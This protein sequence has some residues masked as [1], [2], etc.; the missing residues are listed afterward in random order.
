ML[1]VE[2]EYLLGKVRASDRSDRA[3][4]EWPPHP[5]RLFSAFVAASHECDLGTKA[6]EALLWLQNQGSPSLWADPPCLEDNFRP[7]P[8]VWVPV[9][10]DHSSSGSPI[11]TGIPLF[12]KRA[13]RYFP[14]FTPNNPRVY[15]IWGNT[16][17]EETVHRQALSEIAVNLSYLGHSSSPVRACLKESDIPE[18]NLVPRE[19]GEFLLRVAGPGRLERLENV[20][21]ASLNCH[22]RIEPPIGRFCRYGISEEPGRIVNSGIFKVAAVFRKIKGQILPFDALGTLSS[23]VRKALLNHIP[24]PIPESFSGHQQDG[25]PSREPH[26]AIAPIAN[27]GH[28]HADGHL[29]GFSVLV[30]R[31]LPDIED[32]ILGT[33]LGNLRKLWMGQLGEWEISRCDNTSPLRLPRNLHTRSLTRPCKVWTS[34]TPMA[35]GHFPKSKPGKT[36][37]DIIRRSCL[38]GGLPVPVSIEWDEMPFLKGAAPARSLKTSHKQVRRQ[39]LAYVRL[40]FDTPLRG[41]VVIGAGRYIG[42]GLFLPSPELEMVR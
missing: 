42:F 5:T 28:S 15:F 19:D 26:L 10:D 24:D 8:M 41:P 32:E 14:F 27:V 33:A 38:N 17:D 34:V 39:F 1:V 20:Y 37:E 36:A 11:K 25:V 4:P 16:D 18:P 35:F 12:R 29:M 23:T 3:L 30:P 9:N 40:S 22:R 31:S 2:V 13:E 21:Q 6:R 7:V